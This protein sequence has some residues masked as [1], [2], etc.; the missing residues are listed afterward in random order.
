MRSR[1][2]VRS[3]ELKGLHLGAEADARRHV[4]ARCRAGDAVPDDVVIAGIG[5]PNPGGFE[6][7]RG[8]PH[9][10]RLRPSRAG[11]C[12]GART[13]ANATRAKVMT[14]G[15]TSMRAPRETG[16]PTDTRPAPICTQ[17]AQDRHWHSPI[18]IGGIILDVQALLLLPDYSCRRSGRRCV[19]GGAGRWR[20]SSPGPRWRRGPMGCYWAWAGPSVL[21]VR[22]QA[23]RWST[24]GRPGRR[25]PGRGVGMGGHS[26]SARRAGGHPV[27][28]PRPR[29]RAGRGCVRAGV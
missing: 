20:R 14:V 12:E 25:P 15:S 28:H 13:R 3:P 17:L 19:A 1:S 11:S 6:R 29:A 22:D 2:P 5:A 9:L 18:T 23:A 26:C 27:R 4:D 10:G 8:S 16:S 24:T 21:L 7:G